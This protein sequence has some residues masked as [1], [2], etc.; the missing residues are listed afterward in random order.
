M[1]TKFQAHGFPVTTPTLAFIADPANNNVLVHENSMLPY[2]GCLVGVIDQCALDDL[3]GD[4]VEKHLR[5]VA[6]KVVRG[7]R[8]S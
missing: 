8:A 3:T 7:T 1:A 6:Q 2:F 5:A 4:V